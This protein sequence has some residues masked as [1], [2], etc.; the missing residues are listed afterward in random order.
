MI[1][2]CFHFF[3]LNMSFCICY[4]IDQWRQNIY[5]NWNEFLKLMLETIGDNWKQFFMLMTFRRDEGQ[6]VYSDVGDFMMVTDL[7]CW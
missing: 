5:V 4:K 3:V 1:F 6:N 2:I 7:R